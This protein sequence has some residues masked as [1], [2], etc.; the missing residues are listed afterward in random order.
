[1]MP[2]HVVGL[3]LNSDKVAD[4]QPGIDHVQDAYIWL[5]GQV[6]KSSI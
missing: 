3:L 5:G 6:K 1:M 4:I 2:L